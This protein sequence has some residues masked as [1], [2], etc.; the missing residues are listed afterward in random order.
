M[1]LRKHYG[2]AVAAFLVWGFFTLVLRMVNSH[3]AVEILYFRNLFALLILVIVLFGFMRQ[4]T[5]ETLT[6]LKSMTP[7]ARRMVVILTL[8]GGALLTLNWLVFI[9]VVNEINIKTA[10]FAYLI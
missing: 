10:S 7:Q 2:A 4:Q 5:K 6:Q 9:Y 3:P 8:S 1:D